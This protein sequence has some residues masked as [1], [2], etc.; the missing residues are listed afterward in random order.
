MDEI[1]KAGTP[2]SN[3]GHAFGLTEAMLPLMEPLTSKSWSCPWFQV[4]FD[5]S[6]VG[7]I[8]TSNNASIL[9]EPF[10]SRCP[11]IRLR[12]LSPEELTAFVRREGAKRELSEGGV[13]A[14]AEVLAHPS[15]REHRPS[16]R[17]ASRMLQRATD[18]ENR[19]LLH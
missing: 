4:P 17:V 13:E 6:W 7:W 8:L 5:M 14:I 9:S 1:E 12:N 16:L 3:R 10:R 19:P 11:P 18:M 2:V 15:L